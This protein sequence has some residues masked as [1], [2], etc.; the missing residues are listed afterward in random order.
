MR[1]AV[2]AVL[3]A[4]IGVAVFSGQISAALPAL[5][6]SLPS[7]VA[8]RWQWQSIINIALPLVVV[9]LTGQFVP[10]VA[11]LRNHGY[12]HPPASA[13]LAW[14]ALASALLAPF[15]CHGLN[16]AAVT[17]AICTSP[18]AHDDPRRRYVAGI[19]AGLTYLLLGSFAGSAL[20][21]FATLPGELVATLAGLALFPT[22]VNALTTTLAHAEDRDA[23]LVAFIVSASGMSLFGLGAA[24]WGLIFGLAVHVLLCVR[25]PRGALVVSQTPR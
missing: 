23:A 4:G 12:A 8:P 5:Q 6:L 25:R 9:A 13:L 24:F 21:L 18:E 3:V 15:G 11:L 2:L 10:G 1:Y 22:I 7:W 17:A 14:S 19:A 20:V 16:P